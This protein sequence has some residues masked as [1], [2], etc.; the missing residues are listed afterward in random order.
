M[1][2]W[3][4]AWRALVAAFNR[5]FRGRHHVFR[6]APGAAPACPG[7]AVE[8]YDRSADVPGP[9]REAVVRWG[10]EKAWTWDALEMNDGAA[11]W[12]GRL[13]GAVA[14]A[15]MSRP[16][17]LFRAWFVPLRADD[18]VLFRGTTAP[19]LRGRGISPAMMAAIVARALASGAAAYVDVA[20]HNAPSI[21][22]I[23][24]AGFRRI[25]TRRPVS[26]KDAYA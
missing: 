8:R 9:V 20:V 19:E 15:W 24:K 1:A 4:K 13:D 14:S 21:R 17:S 16:G 12:I 7:L 25:A 26:R 18:L 23:E 5:V 3:R 22:A 10:G 2:P 6:H 11:L